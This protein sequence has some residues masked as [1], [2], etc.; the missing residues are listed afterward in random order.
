CIRERF[1]SH[2]EQLVHVPSRLDVQGLRSE[3]ALLVAGPSATGPNGYGENPE[4]HPSGRSLV[5]CAAG[6][7]AGLY[8]A[9]PLVALIARFAVSTRPADGLRRAPFR[10]RRARSSLIGAV[11]HAHAV[12]DRS[13]PA[14]RARRDTR[15]DA[16]RTGVMAA[17]GAR[18]A[19]RRHRGTARG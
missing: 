1:R 2:V 4:A 7:L 17:R 10:A 16:R 3:S 6:A 18:I 9:D 8:F 5:L 19:D 11:G 13:R 12:R 15:G 14:G